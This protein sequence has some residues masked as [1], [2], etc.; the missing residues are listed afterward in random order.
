[1][2]NAKE[3]LDGAEWAQLLGEVYK[4]A[5]AKSHEDM[6]MS[7]LRALRGFMP[8]QSAVF[9]LIDPR[10][11][12][13]ADCIIAQPL[14][15][16]I[17]PADYESFMRPQWRGCG[18]NT[19]TMSTTCSRVYSCQGSQDGGG[20]A[21]FAGCHM[22]A[23]DLATNEGV[24]GSLALTRAHAQ[25]DFTER[26]RF[27]LE[28]LAPYL[29]DALDEFHSSGRYE[30]L[31][32]GRLRKQWGFT[33]RE[34]EVVECVLYGMTTPEIGVKLGISPSTAKKHLEN[35]YRKVGVNNRM[36]LMKFAQ[37]YVNVR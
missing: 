4:I 20:S 2:V 21:V 35:I 6:R 23:C 22:L 33:T 36:S 31:E 13:I 17:S 37:Q 34:I 29:E 14:G 30:A 19:E 32:G 1:M 16:D 25:G 18:G 12:A 7:A 8:Y 27:V 10:A 28:T 5:R 9:F 3:C 11:C 15:V 24:L 26:D